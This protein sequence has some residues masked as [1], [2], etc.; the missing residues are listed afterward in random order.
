MQLPD[1]EVLRE[2]IAH[3]AELLATRESEFGVQPLVLPT[4]EFFPDV[5]SPDRAGVERLL[6][7]MQK[8]AG[9]SDIP[10]DVEFEA[11]AEQASDSSCSTGACGDL[12]MHSASATSGPALVAHEQGWTLR[13][14]VL[15]L[16]HPVALTT[17]LARLLGAVFIEE[18]RP[19]GY[20]DRGPGGVS[21]EI[22]AVAL[23]FGVLLLEGSHVYSKGCGG[24]QVVNL[25]ELSSAELAVLTALFAAH[26]RH[27]LGPA[28]RAASPTQ[29]AL[30]G[31]AKEWCETNSAVVSRLNLAPSELGA[32]NFELKAAGTGA[33]ALFTWLRS[34]G[35]GRGDR[36]LELA[37]S[38]PTARGTRHASRELQRPR[39]TSNEDAQLKALVENVLAE[40]RE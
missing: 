6:L 12:G 31:L 20:R 28:R 36:E 37:L 21:A 7:R 39:S 4:S 1:N 23:G 10:I 25:T 15:Q 32:G 5:F 40:G 13:P 17:S 8:H 19:D 2:R 30:L 38:A 35:Q 34:W 14:S 27:A 9:L 29:A 11:T 26:R 18:T 24:P 22:A 3:Y 16:R 33:P